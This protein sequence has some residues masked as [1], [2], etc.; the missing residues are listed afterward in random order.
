MSLH[1]HLLAHIQN[2]TGGA[3][4]EIAGADVLSKWNEEPVDFDPIAARELFTQGRHGF[5]WC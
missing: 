2:G 4:G 5:L 1:S 3:V